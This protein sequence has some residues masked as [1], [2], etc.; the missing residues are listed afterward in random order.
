M[1][2]K[3][4]AL[5]T[6]VLMCALPLCSCMQKKLPPRAP[7]QK[8]QTKTL[9]TE[10]DVI[11]AVSSGNTSE[12]ALALEKVP[13]LAKTKTEHGYTMLHIAIWQN[14]ARTAKIL[15]GSKADVDAK[16]EWGFTPLHELIR[17]D[18]TNDR[19]EILDMLIN[20]RAD[21]NAL[22]N[23]GNTP[24]D[25]AE[26]QDKQDFARTLKRYGGK[27]VKVNLDLPPL[28]DFVKKDNEI[29]ENE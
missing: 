8:V 2:K 18:E 12:L 14:N 5:I 6:L 9:P 15:I 21:V 1:V 4:C 25:I 24:L 23:T 16:T 28:P 11:D 7:V 13:A 17:C 27:R 19:K 29:N 10:Q 20:M 3:I 26:I 22:T